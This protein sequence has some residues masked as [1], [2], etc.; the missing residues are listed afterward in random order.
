MKNTQQAIAAFLACRTLAVVG[1]SHDKNKF[2]NYLYRE[3]RKAGYKVY[4][5][6]PKLDMA[7]GDRCFAGLGALPTQPDGVVMVVQPQVTLQILDDMAKLGI[8]QAWLQQG[9]DSAEGEEKAQALGIDLVSGECLL[10]FMEPVESIHR[11]HRSLHRV[12]G[13][14]PK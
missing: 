8:H 3:L 13:R 11:L 14:M 2:G 9:A 6:N 5:V 4:A 7:E 1:V 10:L 12:L